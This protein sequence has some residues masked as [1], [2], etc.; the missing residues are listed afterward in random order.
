MKRTVLYIIMCLSVALSATSQTA[1][2][3][4]ELQRLASTL[5][6]DVSKLHEGYN[7]LTADRTPL[8]V[9]LQNDLLDHI[10]LSL[11]SPEMRQMSQTPVFDFLER[12]FLQLNYPPSEKT[13]AM[14]VRDDEFRFEKG[15]L[16]TVGE[17]LPTDAFNYRFDSHRYVVSWSRNDSL[18][19]VVSFPVEYQLMSGNSKID[20]ENRILEDI[21]Q[22]AIV[23]T[24]DDL[25]TQLYEHYMVKTCT[26]RIYA[27][28][29]SLVADAHHPAETVA[30]MMLSTEM[31]GSVRLRVT[32]VE[33]GF[34]TSTVEVDLK[35]WITYCRN[36]HCQLYYG[37]D[38]F[39]D[40]GSV[41]AVVLAVNTEE[42]YNHV[43]TVTVPA[44][45]IATQKGTVEARLYSYVPTQNIR[46]LFGAYQKSNPKTFVTK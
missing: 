2:R 12:Y 17:L 13:A 30:N 15:T 23:H 8:T 29:G 5:R 34:R 32:Q 4:S 6:I 42:N 36:T 18:L 35:Q 19:L 33:Y 27:V 43:L 45:V 44:D 37:V 26:N 25:K 14:M 28:E 20:A 40:S 46:S 1:F 21:S 7:Y 9:H 22:T 39:G 16:Q 24:P 31:K 10:G 3:T 38:S 11:F 41:N